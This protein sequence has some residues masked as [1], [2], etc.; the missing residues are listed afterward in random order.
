M[1]QELEQ[2]VERAIKLLRVAEISAQEKARER[3]RENVSASYADFV[4]I[5]YSGGKDSDVILHLAKMAGIKYIPIYKATTID[6]PHTIEHA[7]S[8][9]AEVIKPKEGF[10]KLIESRGFPTRRARFCC[11][12]LKEYK[13][14]DVAVQGIRRS[15]STKRKERYK[16]PTICRIYGSKKNHVEVFLPI[17]DWTDKDVEEFIK[18]QHIQCHP[19]YYDELGNFH[20]ERRLGCMCCPLQ[21]QRKLRLDFEAHPRMVSAYIRAGKKWFD[22]HPNTSSRK[23]FGTIYDL[24]F[25]N[26]FCKSYKDY[27]YKTDGGLFERLDCKK[28]LEEH[29]K[30]NLQ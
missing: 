2:K 9:G 30:I 21:S 1:R 17:L 18:E 19:L 6:P 25:H 24:F 16:E 10:F 23:K 15:E 14:L 27:R 8:V 26:V 13:L 5:S 4:E 28:F 7:R 29:F 3:E 20:V 22:T 11:S 12:V